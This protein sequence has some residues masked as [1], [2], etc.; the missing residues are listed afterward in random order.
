MKEIEGDFFMNQPSAQSA[1]SNDRFGQ[2]L[3]DLYKTGHNAQWNLN[4]ERPKLIINGALNYD[5]EGFDIDL[6]VNGGNIASSIFISGQIELTQHEAVTSTSTIDTTGEKRIK[7]SKLIM[8]AYAV[9]TGDGAIDI[10]GDIDGSLA[11]I[12]GKTESLDIF[13]GGDM[14]CGSISWGSNIVVRGNLTVNDNIKGCKHNRGNALETNVIAKNIKARGI[15]G[16]TTS[17]FAFERIDST[18]SIA[19]GAMAFANDTI[20]AQSIGCPVGRGVGTE[21]RTLVYAEL[22]E[23]QTMPYNAEIFAQALSDQLHNPYIDRD[24][25]PQEPEKSSV[26]DLADNMS[27]KMLDFVRLGYNRLNQP[28]PIPIAAKIHK[29]FKIV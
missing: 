25:W 12:E 10:K 4:G 17:V 7:A 16:P 22:L 11:Q 24:P 8:P 1:F 14:N 21:G 19:G 2:L 13:C 18:Y 5:V 20:K 9:I 26:Y 3:S 15:Q 23:T 27:D 6:E 28:L 29:G